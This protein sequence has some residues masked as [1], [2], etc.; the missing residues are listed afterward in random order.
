[1]ADQTQQ[2]YSAM[3]PASLDGLSS[4][5]TIINTTRLSVSD[6]SGRGRTGR[7]RGWRCTGW[8]CSGSRPELETV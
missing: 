7:A 6:G 5:Y 2:A 1:V 3:P 8:R 4:I